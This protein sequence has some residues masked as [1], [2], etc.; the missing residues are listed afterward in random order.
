MCGKKW[1]GEARAA[2]FGEEAGIGR[3]VWGRQLK[4]VA[5]KAPA[6][7]RSQASA[8]SMEARM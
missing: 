3:S 7:I 2:A 4:L 6:A 5:R 1:A 8:A